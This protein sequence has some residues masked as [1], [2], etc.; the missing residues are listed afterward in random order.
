MQRHPPQSFRQVPAHKGH[1]RHNGNRQLQ[2]LPVQRED[3]G[4]SNVKSIFGGPTG[5]PEPNQMAIDALELILAK[6]Q[7]GEVIGVVIAALHHDGMAGFQIGGMVG[8]YS[9]I[10]AIEMAKVDLIAGMME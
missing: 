3:S 8:G 6:A 7:A 5:L 9:M 10:G 4:L 1:Q 2:A